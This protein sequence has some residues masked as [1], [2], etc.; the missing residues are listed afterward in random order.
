MNNEE[1][2][3]NLD[4]INK[5]TKEM[6]RESE[7]YDFSVFEPMK[8]RKRIIEI[9]RY[10]F[11]NGHRKAFIKSILCYI[12]V[13]W[14]TTN[15][16]YRI[17]LISKI[18]KSK[19]IRESN[20]Y[21]DFKKTEYVAFL[22]NANFKN[23][24]NVL[25]ELSQLAENSI[26]KIIHTL[27]LQLNF[28]SS[29]GLDE[30]IE[31][32]FKKIIQICDENEKIWYKFRVLIEIANY[33]KKK[34]KKILK[35]YTKN[36][37]FNF[38]NKMS[39]ID[40]HKYFISI[41]DLY[42]IYESNEF[43]YFIKQEIKFAL[44]KEYIIKVT[45]L[46]RMYSVY[47][48]EEKKDL[49]M[50]IFYANKGI[51]L[52]ERKELTNDFNYFDLL[53]IRANYLLK[54]DQKDLAF[55]DLK[56]LYKMNY[57]HTELIAE[58]IITPLL[59]LYIEKLNYKKTNEIITE[60]LK[61]KLSDKVALIFYKLLDIVYSKQKK[62]K[63]AYENSLFINKY[64]SKLDKSIEKQVAKEK[65]SKEK[66]L[67]QYEKTELIKQKNQELSEL[68][69]K[70]LDSIEYASLIQ[71]SILPRNDE[72]S[73]FID[74]FFIIWKP[75]DIV[76]GDFYWFFPIPNSKNYIISVIDCT[77]HGVPGAFMSMTA[78][79]ILNNIVREKRIYEP[80]KILILL[81]K[82]IR[83]TLRQQSK[84]SQQDGM[85]MSLCYIDVNLQEIHF[86][87]AMQFLFLIR[88]NQ[89]EIE[90]IRGNRFSI[91]G[92][93][94]EEERIFTKHII[95]YNSG[96]SIYLL[97]DGLA[98]QKVRIDGKETKFKIR[99]VREMIL[100]YNPLPMKE[101][102]MKIEEELAELQ[103]NIEQ[104]DDI[105]VLGVKL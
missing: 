61:K 50:S 71:S 93:Q 97:S 43:E 24:Y 51:S 28:Y 14:L 32:L 76:G 42:S 53:K 74:K 57:L 94:K 1:L 17:K 49:V 86:S 79:S 25:I 38:I 80:D 5:F 22:L 48:N 52:L 89:Y 29:L 102:K 101:Q 9:K 78:N 34:E 92:R 56:K 90:R 11:H 72:L 105:M 60:I 31:L 69:K 75:R 6:F 70:I 4:Y 83:Y 7:T 16:L 98:D 100:K 104:R 62:Y 44:N 35:N 55:E 88:S 40:K 67:K 15:K 73:Q 30:K 39:D 77:G 87:G 12:N 8:D 63:K 18:I 91:G 33:N 68:N 19:E 59:T 47:K 45:T 41:L 81:H 2:K 20:L 21:Y 46:Y 27:F 26:N 66:F 36:Y 54:S 84:E 64:S 85:D 58:N 37:S 103:G 23:A 65:I 13:I 82:E 96:D 3:N 99:R 95:Q 10:F